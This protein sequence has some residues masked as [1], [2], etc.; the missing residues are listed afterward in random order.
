MAGGCSHVPIGFQEHVKESR[1]MCPLRIQRGVILTKMNNVA[2]GS[3]CGYEKF[4]R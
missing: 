1:L 2:I 4:G 3:R